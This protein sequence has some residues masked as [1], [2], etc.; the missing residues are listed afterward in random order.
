MFSIQNWKV[1]VAYAG[2]G[3][4]F[5]SFCT[6]MGMLASPVIAH[7]DKFGDIECT[8]LKVVGKSGDPIAGSIERASLT[9]MGKTKLDV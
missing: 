7:K 5:G 1:K 6:K 9:V 2:C 8:S 4:L 3:C